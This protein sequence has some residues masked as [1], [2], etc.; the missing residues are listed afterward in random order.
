[1]RWSN[2]SQLNSARDRGQQLTRRATAALLF[3]LAFSPAASWP[4]LTMASQKHSPTPSPSPSPVSGA[5]PSP[6]PKVSQQ[7][8]PQESPTPKKTAPEFLVVVDP[9]HGGEDKGVTLSTRLFEKDITLAF[10]RELRKELDDRGIAARL[11]RENDISLPIDKRAEITNSHHNIVYIGV[12]AGR[13]G[14]GV[15][16]YSASLPGASASAGPFVP[17]SVAQ[18]GA[19]PRSRILMKAVVSELQRKKLQAIGLDAPLRPLN[20]IIA[21]AIAVELASYTGDAGSTDNQKIQSAVASSIATAIA[22][23]RSQMGVHP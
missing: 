15:R 18:S 20:N 3:Y 5:T 19:L 1:M 16:V 21:P 22:N 17:W 6:A 23:S 2:T 8:S 9:S 4:S 7:A 14:M 12:H 11:L 13:P 10:A